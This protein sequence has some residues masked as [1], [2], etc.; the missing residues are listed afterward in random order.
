M[1]FLRI[2]TAVW[3]L[4]VFG[5]GLMLAGGVYGS[6]A[7]TVRL[8]E[9]MVTRPEARTLYLGGNTNVNINR[10]GNFT[11][12]F[13]FEQNVGAGGADNTRELLMDVNGDGLTDIAKY[14][15]PDVMLNLG[16]GTWQASTTDRIFTQ[17]PA[18][19]QQTHVVDID[20]D[21]KVEEVST[22][23]EKWNDIYF[24]HFDD[25]RYPVTHARLQTNALISFKQGVHL[26]DVNSDNLPDIVVSGR[27]V[28]TASGQDIIYKAIWLNKDGGANWEKVFEQSARG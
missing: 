17:T 15:Y 2:R 22:Y 8:P 19:G 3:V 24:L 4:S 12:P 20:A 16:D 10:N 7:Q 23:W 25:R 5:L 27:L 14:G 13:E 28:D 6:E 18:S 1:G 9:S 26:L 21:G 11:V